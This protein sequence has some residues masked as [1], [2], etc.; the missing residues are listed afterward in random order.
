MA[1]SFE[2]KRK[3][4]E[5]IIE[6]LLCYKCKAVPGTVEKQKNRYVCMNAHQLCEDCKSKCDCGSQVGNRP[7][8][9]VHQILKD[10]PVYCPHYK[11]G[12]REMLMQVKD[13]EDHQMDCVFREVYC[14]E[15]GCNGK[16]VF[17][18]ISDHF[19]ESHDSESWLNQEGKSIQSNVGL[20]LESKRWKMSLG[21]IEFFPILCKSTE[22]GLLYSWIY[23]LGSRFD[24]KNYAYTVS[25]T[26]KNGYKSTIHEN[27]RPLDDAA[28]DIIAEKAVFT[29]GLEFVKKLRG[30]NKEWPIEVTIH[31]LKEEVK[32]KDEESGVEDESD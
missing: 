13:L 12:C 11:T 20:Q 29:I 28:K 10:L 21:N 24:A 25:V 5:N 16:I 7:N 30:D 1:S 23:I 2:F 32:D 3:S 27:V 19:S 15:I 4:L 18:D 9:L 22:N 26:G 17:K 8:P 14:P 31:A 6:N